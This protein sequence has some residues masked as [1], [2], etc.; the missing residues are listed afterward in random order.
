MYVHLISIDNNIW[1][2]ITDGPFIPKKEVDS[3]IK[4]P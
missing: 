3:G 1:V 2:A 4:L